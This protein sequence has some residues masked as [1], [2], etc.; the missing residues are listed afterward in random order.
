MFVNC[1][2]GYLVEKF[3]HIFFSYFAFRKKENQT[4]KKFVET[5]AVCRALL[6]YD[7][8]IAK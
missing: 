6:D 5:V 8:C 3:L 1:E 2:H 7:L 4:K